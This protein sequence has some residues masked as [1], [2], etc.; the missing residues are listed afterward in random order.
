MGFTPFSL[1]GGAFAFGSFFPSFAAGV[2]A[3]RVIIVNSAA[4][5]LSATTRV[6]SHG[7]GR[8]TYI[9]T[10]RIPIARYSSLL[11]GRGLYV[12]K[13]I[14]QVLIRI[15]N[16]RTSSRRDGGGSDS[17]RGIQIAIAGTSLWCIQLASRSTMRLLAGSSSSPNLLL[18]LLLCSLHSLR[19]RH[20]HRT[21]HEYLYQRRDSKQYFHGCWIVISN[22]MVKLRIGSW[23]K[24]LSTIPFFSLLFVFCDIF[25]TIRKDNE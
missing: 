15:H 9:I 5:A 18:L 20:G 6:D 3:G 2:I 16:Q 23:R 4:R 24:K 12:F 1:A 8:S 13:S 25:V 17:R 21:R 14:S 22:R 11:H 7:L 19:F 10:I